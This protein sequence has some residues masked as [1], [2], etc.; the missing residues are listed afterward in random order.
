M[1]ESRKPSRDPAGTASIPHFAARME[2]RFHSF[3]ERRA[4][5]RGLTSTVIAYTGY[6]APGWV[7]VLCRVLLANP[8][9]ETYRVEI[10]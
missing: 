2:D 10:E 5:K 8:V 9:I 3:R 6:G 4:R 1:T 7:R